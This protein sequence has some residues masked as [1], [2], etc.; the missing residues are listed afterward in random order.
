MKTA[1]PQ[2]APRDTITVERI[3]AAFNEAGLRLTRPRQLIAERLAE[4]AA[5]RT[6][7]ATDELWQQLQRIN[8]QPGRATLFRAV[9]VL[10]DP[11]VL[12]RIELGD[13]TRRYRV[14]DSGQH[15]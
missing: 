5:N 3:L 9:E 2:A 6:D 4:H 7:F 13:G 1:T 15:H 14:C 8:P 12:D 10:V 11:G